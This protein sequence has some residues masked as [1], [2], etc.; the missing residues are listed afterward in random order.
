M[1]TSIALVWSADRRLFIGLVVLQFVAAALLVAQVLAVRSVLQ[2]IITLGER[3]NASGVIGWILV[4]AILTGLSAICGSLQTQL[5]RLLGEHVAHA[6][7]NRVLGVS[8]KVGLRHFES[9]EFFN[10]LSR[11]QMSALSRPY[12]VTQGVLSM[13]GA[14]VASVALGVALFSLAP[15]LVPLVACGGVPVLVA[16]RR[17]SRLE[18]DFS[19]QQTPALRLRSYFG[20]LQLGRD[21]AKEVRALGL[22]SWL[23][24]RFNGIYSSYLADLRNHVRRRTGLSVLG[25]V[26][27]S[28]VLGATLLLMVW[29][30]LRGSLDIAGA[31]AALVAIRMLMAQ[32]QLVFRGAQS[33]FESG[34]FLDDLDDFLALGAQARD[35]DQGAVAPT[36]F[37]T[38]RVEAV[39]FS[40]PESPQRALQGVD[41]ELRAGEI[42][43][44]VGENGS[45]KTTLAKLLAG[46]YEPDGGSIRWDERDLSEFSSSSVRDRVT[47]VFQDFVRFALTAT[48]NIATGRIGLTVDPQR[49]RMA[50]RSAG[51]EQALDGLPNGFDTILSRMFAGGQDLSGG[52][53]QRVALARS[54]YRDAPLVILD[55]PTASLDPRAEHELF[56][57]LRSALRGRTALFISHRFATVRGADRI[58]VMHEGRVVEQGTHEELIRIAGRYAE[59]YRLQATVRV[60]GASHDGGEAVTTEHDDRVQEAT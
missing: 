6:M 7:W 59:L 52:Q 44:L 34:L 46:L 4:L 27:A 10:Q 16:S 32:V 55:E 49:V 18:F 35:E 58:Y 14:T 48:E 24:E 26:G 8:T 37:D 3:A 15:V 31:G 60:G 21:E 41:V 38:I 39:T 33:V 42:V 53:W 1:S 56:T 5:Q 22:Q 28:I 2:A 20:M 50:A 36:S 40:Y 30:I 12:Q 19:V 11:V 13:A 17:E 51:A 45:G 29:L 47:V 9:S 57:T 54:F 43:A 25:Q 23:M